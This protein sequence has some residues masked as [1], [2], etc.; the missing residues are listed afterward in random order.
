MFN[1]KLLL[2]FTAIFFAAC[3]PEHRKSKNYKSYPDLRIKCKKETENRF[4][5]CLISYNNSGSIPNPPALINVCYDMKFSCAKS[6]AKVSKTCTKV[7]LYSESMIKVAAPCFY[8]SYI[9]YNIKHSY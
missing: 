9:I 8:S 7:S 5:R 2:I 3:I 1:I 4:L 6:S